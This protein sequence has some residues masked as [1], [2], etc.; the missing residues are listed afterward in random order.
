[1]LSVV[2]AIRVQPRRRPSSAAIANTRLPIPT[3]QILGQKEPGDIDEPEFGPPVEPADDLAGLRIA[4]EHR[5]RAK[6]VVSG[7][8]QIVGAET[9]GDHR[10][11][12][13]IKLIGHADVWVGLGIVIRHIRLPSHGPCGRA[14]DRCCTSSPHHSGS[15]GL[16]SPR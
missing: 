1:M 9:I 12:A 11:I 10:Y 5:E 7:L 3:A 6:I 2:S 16:H 13:G 15:S 14:P 8:A 4:D